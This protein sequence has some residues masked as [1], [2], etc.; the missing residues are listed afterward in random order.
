MLFD[1]VCVSEDV[2]LNLTIGTVY[3]IMS[4]HTVHVGVYLDIH[5]HVQSSCSAQPVQHEACLC[6]CCPGCALQLFWLLEVPRHVCSNTKLVTS[7]TSY[8]SN[9]QLYYTFSPSPFPSPSPSPPPSFCPSPSP[10]PPPSFCPSPLP[11]PPSLSS[12]PQFQ[13]TSQM[14]T[15]AVSMRV[16]MTAFQQILTV[17]GAPMYL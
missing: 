10:S 11:S 9:F 6:E 1:D 14:E 15:S 4:N 17:S 16:V 5:V 3:Y 12:L 2:C 13:M 8:M 7:I